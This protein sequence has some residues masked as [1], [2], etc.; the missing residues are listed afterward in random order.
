MPFMARRFVISALAAA[1]AFV[2][3]PATA[4]ETLKL[5]VV[6]VLAG[7]SAKAGESIVRGLAI[8]VDEI[9]A[10]GGVLGKKLELVVRD[11][12]SNPAKGAVA[13]RELVQR[14]KVVAF[15]G[16][17]DTPVSLGIVPFANQPK[18][19]FM[20]VWAAGPPITRTGAAE[21][22]ASQVRPDDEI[23]AAAPV[24]HASRV[25]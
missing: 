9:N 8:A 6:T 4:Q 5:G 21:Y 19:P 25:Y 11:D 2:V 22:Y 3:T 17:L 20:G 23:L 7:Q 15:F 13:A 24:A 1:T 16:G 10:K 18:V 14:E 12:E